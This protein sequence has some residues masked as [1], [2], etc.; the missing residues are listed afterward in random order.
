MILPDTL[1]ILVR[2]NDPM[3]A[4]HPKGLSAVAKKRLERKA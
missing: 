3:H 2:K 1:K 4:C